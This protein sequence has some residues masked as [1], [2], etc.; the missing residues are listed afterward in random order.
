VARALPLVLLAVAAA[1]A[2]E[3]EKRRPNNV[4]GVEGEGGTIAGVVRFKGKKPARRPVEQVAGNPFCKEAHAAEPLLEDQ[5]VFGRN[6]DDDTLQNVLVYVSK[7]LEGRKFDPPKAP[8]LVDQ[9]KCVYTPHV[10]G[11]M[12][13]QPLEIRNSDDT[14]H[15]VM[16]TP[17]VN[18]G[19]N[20]GMNGRGTLRK[21]FASAELKVE[22]RC[23]MHKW[24]LAYVHVLDHPYF[25]VTSADGTFTL[26]G[27]PPGEYEVAVLH[28][29]SRV[30]AAPATVKVK[31]EAGKTSSADFTYGPRKPE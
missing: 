26:K 2:Q 31:V 5:F 7:G 28:E 1:A 3:A 20:D 4:G 12:A 15:N 16:S 18:R 24:M 13:G 9:V 30:E 6:G 29:A 23:F 17:L 25:A 21:V 19:F 22:L 14:L 11:V 27:L 10:V 8:A